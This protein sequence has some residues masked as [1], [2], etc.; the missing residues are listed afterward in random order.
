MTGSGRGPYPRGTA[1]FDRVVFFSDAV[2]AIA[3]TLVAVGIGIPVVAD[4][5]SNTELWAALVDKL[6]AIAAYAFT[7]FWVAFYWRANH[8]FTTRLTA[9]SGR[10]LAAVLLYLAF[11]ALLPFPAATL[12]EYYNAVALSFFLLFMAAV[13]ALEVLLLVVADTDG[14][15]EVRLTPAARR[16]EVAG[17]MTPVAAAVVAVPVSFVNVVAGVVTFIVL[18]L[19]FGALV[20][21]LFRPR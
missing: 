20:N 12:G 4:R 17:S 21:R 16:F 9:M 19:S 6:P 7:F 2:F 15:L 5:E 10:Y 1:A 11:I 18:A 8:A 14:L 3:L 13:S